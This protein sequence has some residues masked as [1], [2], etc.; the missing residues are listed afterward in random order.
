M[1]EFSVS[2]EHYQ[3]NDLPARFRVLELLPGKRGTHIS[4]LLRTVDWNDYPDFC[5]ISYAWG[6]IHKRRPIIC[7]GKWLQ[8]SE[9]LYAALE[10]LRYESEPRYLWADA[11][12]YVPQADI[13]HSG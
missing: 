5:A 3:Y 1:E 8:V 11:V 6:D 7:H 2:L 12:W 4:I 13:R 10:H 9:N